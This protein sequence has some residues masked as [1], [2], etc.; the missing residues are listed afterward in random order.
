MAGSD[1]QRSETPEDTLRATITAPFKAIASKSAQRA[2]LG[3]LFFL[4]TVFSLLGV[5]IVSYW[6]FYYNYVPQISLERLVHLQFGDGHPTG[7][8]LIG[9]E[10]A[11]SQAYDVTVILYLPR[12]PSNLAAG[13]FMVDLALL[14]GTHGAMAN[15]SSSTIMR[16]R[17]PAILTYSSRLVDTARRISRMPLYMLN[18]KRE[19]DTLKIPMMERVEFMKGRKHIPGTA[20]LEI[21]SDERMQFYKAMIRFDA[22][23]SGLRWLM[24]NWRILSFVTFSSMFWLTS[25]A[26]TSAVWMA[27]SSSSALEDTVPEIEKAES[28]DN[29]GSVK[30]ESEDDDHFGLSEEIIQKRERSLTRVIKEEEEIEESTMIEPLMP[31]NLGNTTEAGEASASTQSR[32]RSDADIQGHRRMLRRKSPVIKDPKD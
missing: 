4:V 6:V 18:W 22:R 32:P 19:A 21:E 25:V 15:V 9:P 12:T 30:D 28:E 1:S 14:E 29:G 5:S 20:R 24:Y 27:L 13:N 2:Y 26:A 23:F 7:S 11:H 3:T 31:V 17:R 10:L 16:S 8:A